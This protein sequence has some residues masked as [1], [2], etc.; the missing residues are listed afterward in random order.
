M[1]KVIPEAWLKLMS[2]EDRK[3]IGQMS[4]EEAFQ[5]FTARSERQLQSQIV[6]LLRLKGIEV[7]WHRT[8]KKSA[9]TI[10]WP[11][12]TFCVY[13]LA[14]QQVGTPDGTRESKILRAWQI[15]AC[16]WEIKMPDGEL[17]KEQ[18]KMYIR[19]GTR[20]NGWIYR[21]IRSVDEALKELKSMGIK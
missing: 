21:V 19:L 15:F 10:G 13:E 6:N 1:T 3:A 16:A 4:A 20:P 18:E 8:D 11:D 9:A 12:L 7:L 2:K 14:P 5:A 17:S